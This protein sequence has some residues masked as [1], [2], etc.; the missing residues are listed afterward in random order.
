M[1]DDDF[2]KADRIAK[3]VIVEYLSDSFIHY[4][5]TDLTAKEILQKL[6]AIYERKSL[7]V[8]LALHK[9]LLQLNSQGNMSL[10]KH[11]LFF[12]DLISSLIAA[13]AKLEE[14]D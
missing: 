13:G 14:T 10:V 9:Q 2:K 6:D 4:A 7:A 11:F 8:Q 12:D 1:K 3:G 5:D